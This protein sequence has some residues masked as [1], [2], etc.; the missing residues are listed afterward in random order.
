MIMEGMERGLQVLCILTSRQTPMETSSGEPDI[1][2][3]NT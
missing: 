1:M 3:A 2:S